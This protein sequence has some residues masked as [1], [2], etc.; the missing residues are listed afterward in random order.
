M[1]TKRVRVALDHHQKKRNTGEK[2]HHAEH[3]KFSAANKNKWSNLMRIV[4]N[5]YTLL[6]FLVFHPKKSLR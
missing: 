5:S 2:K 1:V 3:A 6:R 4:R